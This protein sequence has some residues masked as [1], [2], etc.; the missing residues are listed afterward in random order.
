MVLDMIYE[1]FEDLFSE[2]YDDVIREQK[3]VSILQADSV[4]CISEATCRDV[5]NIYGIAPEKTHVV[6][7]AAAEFFRPVPIGDGGQRQLAARPFLLYVGTRN[8]YK[9]FESL[10]T[11]YA[12]WR[13]RQD[14]DLVVVSDVPWTTEENR[15]LLELNIEARVQLLHNISDEDLRHLYNE[16]LMFVYP[17]LYEG[18]G[19]PLLEAMACGCPVVASRIPSTVEVAGDCPV[20]FDPR[21]TTDLVAALDV[22]MAE[23]RVSKRT[24]AGIEWAK[25]YSWNNTAR[26][27]INVYRSL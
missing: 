20:Y 22:A 23:G 9:N 17:S 2:P 25:K 10:I 11:A 14:V 4:I 1:L 13:S 12:N 26:G 18:F 24:A 3:R 27:I 15:R 7:L 19:I 21:S 5:Q 16:A 6:P 8:H